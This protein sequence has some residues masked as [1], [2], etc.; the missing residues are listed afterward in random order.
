MIED[1]R[2]AGEGGSAEE[3]DEAAR[4]AEEPT[5]GIKV[6]DRR[7]FTSQGELRE[8]YRFLEDGTGKQPASPESPARPVEPPPPERRAEAVDPRPGVESH[9]G[10]DPHEAVDPEAPSFLDLVGMLAEPAS[11]YL[12][13][14]PLPDGRIGQDLAA[15]RFHIDLLD[16][17][18]RKSRG[19]LDA[20]ESAVLD[21]VIDQ[22]RKRFM[23]KSG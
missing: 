20:R 9:G 12:G 1:E 5:R 7:M 4:R 13:D 10:S 15:A 11:I 16:V 6:T 17:L 14:I 18:R 2:R 22:L 21:D 8:E 23:Q 3:Q 19:N